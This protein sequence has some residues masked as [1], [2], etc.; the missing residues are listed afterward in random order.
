MAPVGDGNAAA[1]GMEGEAW[2]GLS[3]GVEGLLGQ[4]A[5]AGDGG[6]EICCFMVGHRLSLGHDGAAAG[7]AAACG[8][9]EFVMGVDQSGAPG[10][11]APVP[12]GTAAAP[13][14]AK[15]QASVS[16]LAEA[17]GKLGE[18]EGGVSGVAPVPMPSLSGQLLGTGLA[19]AAG[20][21]GEAA[22]LALAD[23]DVGHTGPVGV[24]GDTSG[25][26]AFVAG[27]PAPAEAGQVGDICDSLRP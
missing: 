18:E 8:T 9:G 10:G 26:A 21:A 5:L 11:V 7:A 17:A 23:P 22:G 12:G 4:A 14:P 3:P 1:A 2:A 27:T 6:C 15:G 16:G 13:A 24:S 19:V 25:E 20:N